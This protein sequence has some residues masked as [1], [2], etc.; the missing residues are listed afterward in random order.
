MNHFVLFVVCTMSVEI[1]IQLKFILALIS[2]IDIAKKV[3]HLIPKVTVSDH[4]KEKVI[5]AYSLKMIKFSL[6]IFATFL[7]ISSVLAITESFFFG[8][9]S[10]LLSFMGIIEATIFALAYV[11]LRKVVAK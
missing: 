10:L 4:W 7:C 9:L 6:Q 3:F 1:F 11:Y 2:I 8:F 5:P